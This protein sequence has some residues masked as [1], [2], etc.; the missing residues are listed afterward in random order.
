MTDP[1]VALEGAPDVRDADS[2]PLVASGSGAGCR[3]ARD[4]HLALPMRI[5]RRSR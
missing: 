3:I 2:S 5:A 4:V 1:F